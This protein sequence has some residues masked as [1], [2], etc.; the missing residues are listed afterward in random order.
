MSYFSIAPVALQRA[1]EERP[2]KWPPVVLYVLQLFG[3]VVA[4]D[5]AQDV[6]CNLVVWGVLFC[7]LRYQIPNCTI[8]PDSVSTVFSQIPWSLDFATKAFSSQIMIS[9]Y[10][11]YCLRR[12]TKN[13]SF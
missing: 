13:P 1:R 6:T 11:V 10:C 5:S 12:L 3:F 4:F 9:G 7:S 8:S 2:S